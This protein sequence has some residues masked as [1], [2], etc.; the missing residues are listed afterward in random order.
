MFFLKRVSLLCL[1]FLAAFT[2]VNGQCTS[3]AE[4]NSSIYQLDLNTEIKAA[5]KLKKLKSLKTQ[6]EKCNYS[7]DSVYA[8]LLHKIS[9]IEYES[10]GYEVLPSCI[11]YALEAVKINT[12]GKKSADSA[13]ATKSY[14]NISLF[15]RRTG[16]NNLALKYYDTTMQFVERFPM[17]ESAILIARYER[18]AIYFQLGD[19]QRSIDESSLGLKAAQDLQDSLSIVKFLNQRAQSNLFQRLYHL[20]AEDAFLASTYAEKINKNQHGGLDTESL[21]SLYFEL[22]SS[23]KIQALSKSNNIDFP[24]I[25]SLINKS[26]SYRL[27]SGD[28][29]AISDDYNDYGLYFFSRHKDYGKA[30]A[31]YLKALTYAED[32]KIRHAYVHLNLGAVK[33]VQGKYSE[34][35]KNYLQSLKDVSLNVESITTNPSLLQI[36]LINQKEFV[37]VFLNNQTEYLLTRYHQTRD[38]LFLKACLRTALLTDSVIKSI[39]QEQTGEQSKLFWRNRTREFFT[40]ALQA[41]FLANDPRLAFQFMESSRSVILGDKI[42]ELGASSFLPTEQVLHEQELKETLLNYQ[43]N[44]SSAKA[45]TEEYKKAYIKLLQAKEEFGRFIRSLE[46]NYPS[47]Y[48]YKYADAAPSLEELK[49]YLSANHQ[50]FVHY[51]MGDT[52]T[53]VLGI[54]GNNTKMLRIGKDQFQFKQISELLH[55]FSDKQLLNNQYS[56]FASLSYKLN[57]TLFEPLQ[58]PKGRVVICPDNFL[59]P[60]EALSTDAAGTKML[61]N[62]YAFSYIYS[63]GY[64]LKTFPEYPAKGNFAGF[65]PV[66]FRSSLGLPDLNN[67]AVSLSDAAGNYSKALMYKTTEATKRNFLSNIGNYNIVNVFSHARANEGDE[68]PLLYMQDSVIG[69]SELQFLNKP[70]TKLVVL[71]ACQTTAGKTAT[72]EGIYSL[73]RGFAAAGIPSVA[74]T[75]WKADEETTYSISALFHQYLSTG[76]RKDEALQKA[77][78]EFMRRADREHLLPYYWANMVITGKVDGISFNDSNNNWIWIIAGMSLLLIGIGIV[79]YDKQR[80]S[81]LH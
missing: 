71:S 43:R 55:F 15:Y 56:T 29:G 38:P 23:Y 79:V 37:H 48:Q 39:R 74:A 62:D 21:N 54:S 4:I 57:K 6:F 52:A 30:T 42:N 65:A 47:Y 24:E 14:F 28:I 7:K 8:K 50:S 31:N 13:A 11:P 51:F 26:I 9:I 58:L 5:D 36:N 69:L 27:K 18:A 75:V 2:S 68:E 22:A 80:R 17:Y 77:K 45:G 70:C 10:N 1:V 35:E 40:N 34:A 49:K 64:L 41:C 61:I 25:S 46:T 19:Y 12:S 53:Y 3:G 59:L 66:S 32:S 67:S 73:A 72:G 16:L 44:L 20:A 63:A 78:L 60:F 81:K 33:F 76:M